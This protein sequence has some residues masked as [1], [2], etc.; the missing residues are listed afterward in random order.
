MRETTFVG[1]VIV[2]FVGG[3]VLGLSNGREGANDS[4]RRA[5]AGVTDEKCR[6]SVRE[7]LETG[8]FRR[9]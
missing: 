4:W 6:D 1:L 3:V 9:E 7:A 5:V 2:A 8:P